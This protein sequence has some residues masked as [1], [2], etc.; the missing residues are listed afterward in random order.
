MLLYLSFLAIGYVRARSGFTCFSCFGSGVLVDTRNETEVGV[1][2]R[3]LWSLGPWFVRAEGVHSY[4]TNV[5]STVPTILVLFSSAFLPWTFPMGVYVH[6]QDPLYAE[7]RH[8]LH[9]IPPP[10]MPGH[11]PS[12]K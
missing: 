1:V 6:P 11:R 2:S 8:V 5:R 3:L 10:C 12:A 9:T 7:G 4:P